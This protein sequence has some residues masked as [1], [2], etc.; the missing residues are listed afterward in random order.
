MVQE[1]VKAL[2]DCTRNSDGV[3][4]ALS[5]AL[6]LSHR[7]AKATATAQQQVAYIQVF[8]GLVQLVTIHED[9]VALQGS[10]D[11]NRT[12]IPWD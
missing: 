7:Q 1:P 6:I 3:R 4:I 11:L 9:K 12:G 8:I 5:H 2:H 10:A